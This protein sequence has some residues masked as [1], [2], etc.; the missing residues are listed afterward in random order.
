METAIFLLSGAAVVSYI[1][2][3]IIAFKQVSM[4]MQD[5]FTESNIKIKR[6]RYSGSIP[7]T[8]TEKAKIPSF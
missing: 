5:G 4:D 8:E 3:M 1:L 2:A 7:K 6:V